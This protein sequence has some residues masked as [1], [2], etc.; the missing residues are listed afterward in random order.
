MDNL[1]LDVFFT[2]EDTAEPVTIT[3]ARAWLKLDVAE[4]DLI[5]DELI[6]AARQQCEG[7]LN[8]S[9]INRTVTA[10]LQIGLDLIRLPYGPVKEVTA[11]ENS[12]GELI[13][14]YVLKYEK[15]KALDPATEVKA[16][17]T[18]GYEEPIPRQFKTGILEQVAWLYTNRGD[19]QI[20][21]TIS[22]IAKKI[23][24][25]YRRVT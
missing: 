25:P 11:V 24:A 18:A 22:P 4:D 8:I 19:Q 12:A 2:D 21:E 13:T 5:L 6:T 15:F 7:F 10:W 16:V 23:L 3:E 17:Y 20:T 9:L 14:D 1:I